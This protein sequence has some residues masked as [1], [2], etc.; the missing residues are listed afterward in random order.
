MLFVNAPNEFMRAKI[1][2]V[3]MRI[4]DER[5]NSFNSFFAISENPRVLLMKQ[6]MRKALDGFRIIG[7]LLFV[8]PFEQVLSPKFGDANDVLF[9]RHSNIKHADHTSCTQTF[10]FHVKTWLVSVSNAIDPSVKFE[11]NSASRCAFVTLYALGLVCC[12]VT[13]D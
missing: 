7:N 2:A 9:L 6:P 1:A 5:E 12:A 4:N 11:A 10:P 3:V 13:S 8:R